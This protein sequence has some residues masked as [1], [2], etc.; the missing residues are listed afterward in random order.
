MSTAL[1]VREHSVLPYH[2]WSVAEFHRMAESGLLG[3]SD[4]VE[5]IEWEWVDMAPI[6]SRHA[7]RGDRISRQKVGAGGT[8]GNGRLVLIAVNRA[9]PL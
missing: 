4:R 8:A 3:E 7:S 5:L 6:D 1:E 9:W 2:R